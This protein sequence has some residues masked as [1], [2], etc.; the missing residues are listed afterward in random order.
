M[1]VSGQSPNASRCCGYSCTEADRHAAGGMT[2]WLICVALLWQYSPECS[3]M[4]EECEQWWIFRVPMGRGAAVINLRTIVVQVLPRGIGRRCLIRQK[5][6][7]GG[8][9]GC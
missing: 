5:A 9:W 6:S 8:I 3:L 1:V 7:G 4:V 2:F